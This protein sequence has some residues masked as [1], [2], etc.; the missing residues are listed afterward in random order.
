MSSPNQKS[1]VHTLSGVKRT[2]FLKRK[3][4][5]LSGALRSPAKSPDEAKDTLRTKKSTLR[6]QRQKQIEEVTDVLQFLDQ[7]Q[8]APPATVAAAQPVQP[9][10]AA[11]RS[12]LR[13]LFSL[14]KK[15]SHS[16]SAPIEEWQSSP[17]L[18]ST[19]FPPDQRPS[20]PKL[21]VSSA[22]GRV[23]EPL[24]PQRPAD[25]LQGSGDRL[26]H[27][28]SLIHQRKEE[29]RRELER[30]GDATATRRHEPRQPE[31]D[32]SVA[33][34]SATAAK[35]LRKPAA[36]GTR[37]ADKLAAPTAMRRGSSFRV[38]RQL[39]VRRKS[40]RMSITANRLPQPD[41][42]QPTSLPPPRQAVAVKKPTTA[43]VRVQRRLSRLRISPRK[44][45]SRRSSLA[46]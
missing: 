37:A 12:K 15:R 21:M 22:S 3:S 36:S 1:V 4:K 38:P 43:T 40:I 44:S 39:V 27:Q 25:A 18:S 42:Q 28:V 17:A 2:K 46:P 5:R 8:A 33:P 34:P 16:K 19:Q 9:A 26:A 13:Q 23:S 6:H 35:T 30:N 11:P 32:G 41:E 10:S 7:Q 14:L 24:T 20:P 29:A 31:P 45:D